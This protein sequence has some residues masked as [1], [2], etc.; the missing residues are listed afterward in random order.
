[1]NL[2]SVND[3]INAVPTAELVPLSEEGK[4]VQSDEAVFLI[5]IYLKFKIYFIS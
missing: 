1:M 4:F 3:I 2:K 5:Y